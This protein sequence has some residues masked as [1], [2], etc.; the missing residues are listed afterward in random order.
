MRFGA[1]VE[2]LGL[3]Q[4][5]LSQ[6]DV[7]YQIGLPPRRIDILTGI[8]GVD[9]DEAWISRTEEEVSDLKIPFLG[10]AALVRNKRATGR[11]KDLADVELL[12]SK[13]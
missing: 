13:D 4:D 5:G 11:T 12:E 6:P 3:T 9:F 1:P 2:Q 10:R 7:I 8:D